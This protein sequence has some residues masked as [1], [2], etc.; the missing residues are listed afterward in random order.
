M[1]AHKWFCVVFMQKLKEETVYFDD[2]KRRIG[3]VDS[4]LVHCA[5]SNLVFGVNRYS[6]THL[7]FVNS[8]IDL[9]CF[10]GEGYGDGVVMPVCSGCGLAD[11]ALGEGG[12]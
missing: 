1:Y 2:G 3:K 10:I 8:D 7:C 6:H 11:S 5:K 12:Y 4:M 9:K